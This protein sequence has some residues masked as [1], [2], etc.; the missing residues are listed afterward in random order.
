MAESVDSR[1]GLLEHE[2][3]DEKHF[4]TREPR[5]NWL[6]IVGIA[7][8]TICVLL[9]GFFGGWQTARHRDGPNSFPEAR[10]R[11]LCSPLLVLAICSPTDAGDAVKIGNVVKIFEQD[12]RFMKPPPAHGAPEPIWDSMLPLGLGYVKN[13]DIPET[14]NV[15][16]I[17]A[18][19]QLHCLV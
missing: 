4:T 9:S 11:G 1:R 3:A 12:A 18:M 7:V 10:P 5:V 19:H 6:H 17:S 2:E 15:S 14:E 16:T 8:F 13:P